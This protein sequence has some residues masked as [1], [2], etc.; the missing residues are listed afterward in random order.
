[1]VHSLVV[2]LLLHCSIHLSLDF[3]LNIRLVLYQ[4][5][6]LQAKMFLESSIQSS[7][8]KRNILVSYEKVE[9]RNSLEHHTISDKYERKMYSAVAV[10]EYRKHD[11]DLCLDTKATKMCI[12]VRRSMGLRTIFKESNFHLI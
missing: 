6:K 3:L 1:M 11:P 4:W 2:V 5:A 12:D 9:H 8:I 7:S 10:V